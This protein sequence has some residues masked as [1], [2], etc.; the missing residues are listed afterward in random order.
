M[1]G[2]HFMCMRFLLRGA[3]VKSRPLWLVTSCSSL[4]LN[5]PHA[6]IGLGVTLRMSIEKI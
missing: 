2:E 6:K 5:E 1:M 3:G 4:T